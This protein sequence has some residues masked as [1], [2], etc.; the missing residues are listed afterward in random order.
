MNWIWYSGIVFA[1]AEQ[2][3]WYE[4]QDRRFFFQYGNNLRPPVLLFPGS[5]GAYAYLRLLR[6]KSLKVDYEA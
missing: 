2:S 4:E 5:I 1:K 3:W 6:G